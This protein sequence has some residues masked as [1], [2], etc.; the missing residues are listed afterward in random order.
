[1]FATERS[2]VMN[3]Q[4]ADRAH[5]LPLLYELGADSGWAGGMA[6]VTLALLRS[7]RLPAGARLLDAGCGG[8]AMLHALARAGWAD[9]IG[10]DLHPVALFGHAQ[11]SAPLS[12]ADLHHLPFT[13]GSFD[14]FLAL[15][16]FDQQG[17]VLP[18]ALAEARR[19]LRPGGVALLR[20]SAYPWLQGAHDA[21]FGTGRRYAR[22]E[23]VA[24][25]QEAGLRVVR[26][27]H[28][29]SLLAPPVIALRLAQRDDLHP[30]AEHLYGST[31]ANRVLAAAL[32]LEARW[33]ARR[34]LPF[35]LSLFVLGEKPVHG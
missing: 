7:A 29:N 28:A 1:M 2:D 33:L 4:P 21:A 31:A 35:G 32:R 13:E 26:A 9:A 18:A 3:S 20:V 14:A 19:V 15:D 22:R 23:F 5:L 30:Q 12:G 11:R 27:T 25:V 17:I 10:V 16:S 8:G 34:N 6:A 24:A